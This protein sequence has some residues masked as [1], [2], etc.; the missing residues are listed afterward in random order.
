MYRFAINKKK[1]LL[2]VAGILD[3]KLKADG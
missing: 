2:K 3:K 1:S